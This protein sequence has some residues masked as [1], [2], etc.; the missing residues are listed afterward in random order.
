MN[1][2]GLAEGL[3]FITD[4]ALALYASALMLRFWMRF[5]HADFHHPLSQFIARITNPPLRL[6]RRVVP[7]T[8]SIDLA[9][10]AVLW[11]VEIVRVC[12]LAVLYGAVVTSYTAMLMLAVAVALRSF[13]LLLIILIVVRA[14]LSWFSDPYDP[15]QRLLISVTEPLMAPA[16]RLLPALGGIDL[17]PMLVVL[18]LWLLRGHVIQSLVELCYRL[19]PFGAPGL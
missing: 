3:A 16:R 18:V 2:E 14:L 11:V 9:V 7:D 6:C 15:F 8:G 10:L 19:G 12:T 4:T 1:N 13:V 17:S 5:C